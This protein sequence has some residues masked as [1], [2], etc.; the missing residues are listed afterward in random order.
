MQISIFTYSSVKEGVELVTAIKSWTTT[1]VFSHMY[2]Q[3]LCPSHTAYIS[4]QKNHKELLKY[5]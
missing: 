5:L 3:K 2:K 1:S 4:Y